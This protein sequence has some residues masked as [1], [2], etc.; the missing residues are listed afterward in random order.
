M[1]KWLHIE[2]CETRTKVITLVNHRH[3]QR[4]QRTK[5]NSIQLQVVNVK[6]VKTCE[7]TFFWLA[8]EVAWDRKH[9]RIRSS[10][11]LTKWREILN[12]S[13]KADKTKT[14]AIVVVFSDPFKSCWDEIKKGKS[15]ICLPW[16][17]SVQ[18]YQDCHFFHWNP[19]HYRHVSREL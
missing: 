15:K 12:Q 18:E 14:K 11:W 1:I 6:R 16:A 3:R 17:Q 13:L 19:T 9:A 5:Q 4:I 2:C 10:D 7:D 8:D